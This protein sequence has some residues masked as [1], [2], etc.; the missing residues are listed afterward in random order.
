MAHAG[1]LVNIGALWRV[2]WEEAFPSLASCYG[3]W[4]PRAGH[5][6]SASAKE[7]ICRGST[8]PKSACGWL[9]PL[10]GAQRGGV[11]GDLSRRGPR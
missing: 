7:R 4:R 6:G 2:G 11:S 3:G 10:E 9:S 8:P 5:G 1:Q